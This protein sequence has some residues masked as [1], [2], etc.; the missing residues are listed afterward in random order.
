MLININPTNGLAV[1]DQI[2]RQIK[3]AVANRVL[4]P[5]DLVPSVR[6]LAKNL[7]INPNTVARA[8]RE[9]QAEQIIQTVRG[10]GLEI[11]VAAPEIC[12]NARQELIRLRL[13]E[14]LEEA[15]RSQLSRTQV[16][17]LFDKELSQYDETGNAS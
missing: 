5:G 11:T 16:K 13:R 6:E 3:F 8:Y 17:Q 12:R 14:V 9:L 15:G 1:Y 10:T 2:A 4:R 7:A